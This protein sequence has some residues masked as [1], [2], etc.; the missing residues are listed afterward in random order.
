MEVAGR[1]VPR[2][3]VTEWFVLWIMMGVLLALA[4]YWIDRRHRARKRD[5][6]HPTHR[7]A[8]TRGR[9]RHR[10]SRRRG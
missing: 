7:A 1:W 3:V 4:V 5:E 2:E 8:R 10:K 6:S 9:G